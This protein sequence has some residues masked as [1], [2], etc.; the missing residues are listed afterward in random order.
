MALQPRSGNESSKAPA[1][2][3]D[4]LKERCENYRRA[5]HALQVENTALRV[6]VAHNDELISLVATLRA[7]ND[8]LRAANERLRETREPPKGL[9]EEEEMH[10]VKDDEENYSPLD[11]VHAQ[12]VPPLTAESTAR[13]FAV[14]CERPLSEHNSDDENQDD[15]R[16]ELLERELHDM[17]DDVTGVVAAAPVWQPGPSDDFVIYADPRKKEEPTRR[18]APSCADAHEQPD[19]SATAAIEDDDAGLEPPLA[20]EDDAPNE[21]YGEEAPA[22][23]APSEQLEARSAAAL[24]LAGASPVPT[25]LPLDSTS[26]ATASAGETARVATVDSAAPPLAATPGGGAATTAVSSSSR[27]AAPSSVARRR[28]VIDDDDDDADDEAERA[29]ATGKARSAAGG[30]AVWSARR[31]VLSDDE[32]EEEASEASSSRGGVD[33]EEDDAGLSTPPAAT[34][35]GGG[36]ARRAKRGGAAGG[37]YRGTAEPDHTWS[38]HEDGVGGGGGGG[39]KRRWRNVLDDSDDD[40]EARSTDGSESAGSLN[41]FIVSDDEDDDEED[42]GSEDM[43]E[44]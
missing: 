25:E 9:E 3:L 15:N 1:S 24:V 13:V 28:V 29:D 37:R 22:E 40:V 8:A 32:E 38:Y 31:V 6:K 42:D 41:D 34:A 14:L 33:D 16:E 5:A 10:E 20:C 2:E 21:V 27:A 12:S 30:G 4:A 7:E 19:D 23:E 36:A 43:E 39:G 18:G 35:V 11:R 44:A 26:A 17:A